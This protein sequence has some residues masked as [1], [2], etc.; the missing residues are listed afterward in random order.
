MMYTNCGTLTFYGGL[1]LYVWHQRVWGKLVESFPHAHMASPLLYARRPRSNP[2]NTG[3]PDFSSPK[4]VGGKLPGHCSHTPDICA[5][6]WCKTLFKMLFFNPC[7]LPNCIHDFL[8]LFLH[9]ETLVFIWNLEDRHPKIAC[10]PEFVWVKIWNEYGMYAYTHTGLWFSSK[11]LAAWPKCLI[12]IS[13]DHERKAS[14]SPNDA[15]HVLRKRSFSQ[16]LKLN[17]R[18]SQKSVQS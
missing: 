12:S 1:V 13:F 6:F 8:F 5:R 4:E 11:S 18:K 16:L 2:Q 17:N 7:A 15:F 14:C 10:T 9:T 3:L